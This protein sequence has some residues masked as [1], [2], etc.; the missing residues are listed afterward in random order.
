MESQVKRICYSA[1]LAVVALMCAYLEHFIP[2]TLLLPFPGIK[3]GLSNLVT[4]FAAKRLNCRYAAGVLI[5]RIGLSALLFGSVTTFFFSLGGALCAYFVMVILLK[6][7]QGRVSEIGISVACAA[8]HQIGQIVTACIMFA[9]TA[10]LRY[11][12]VLLLISL[13]TGTL[14]GIVLQML[15]WRIPPIQ[16][17]NSNGGSKGSA[18]DKRNESNGTF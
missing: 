8:S 16:R 14:V 10:M 18:E 9:N 5:I 7:F 11:L 4:L 1:C 3:L 12:P 15:L 13:I 2:L 6:F 17:W